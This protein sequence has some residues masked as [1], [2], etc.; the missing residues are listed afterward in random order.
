MGPLPLSRRLAVAALALGTAGASLVI[1]TPTRALAASH[2]P[3]SCTIYKD[4]ELITDNGPTYLLAVF[5]DI[6]PDSVEKLPIKL[7]QLSSS[8]TWVIVAT[9]TGNAT[10]TCNGTT[11]R[12]YTFPG[13]GEDED[14]ACG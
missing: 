4:L 7:Q 12:E 11:E 1:A 14:F 9:G 3:R 6:C 2:S 8:G 5:E 13:L 10:Y